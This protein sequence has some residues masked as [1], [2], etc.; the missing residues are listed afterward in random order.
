MDELAAT[1][2]RG[3]N[4]PD[5]HP[6]AASLRTRERMKAAY[7]AGIVHATGLI[8]HG[9]GE[10]FDYLLGERTGPAAARA[11][12]CAARC[13]AAAEHPVLSVNGNVAALAA[14]A[15]VELA[16]ASGALIEVNLFHRAPDRLARIAALLRAAGHADVLGEV[17]DARIPHLASDRALA[18]SRGIIAADLVVVPLEDGDRAEALVALG[19]VVVTIEL[20]PLTRAARAAH[21]TVVDELTRALPLITAGVRAARAAGVVPGG[22]ADAVSTWDNQANLAA[23]RAE[24][25]ARLAAPADPVVRKLQG[26]GAGPR[27]EGEH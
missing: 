24:M 15:V 21:V 3:T 13:I 25:A 14:P 19:K 6:R 8:A 1:R 17:P 20:N 9:R 22:L 26:R 12:D 11:A 5:D 2:A 18:S 16:A 23:A 4:I 27:R 10:A 7:E